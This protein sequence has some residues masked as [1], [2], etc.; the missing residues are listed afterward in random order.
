[1]CKMFILLLVQCVKRKP[2][3]TVVSGPPVNMQIQPEIVF[4]R[5]TLRADRAEANPLSQLLMPLTLRRPLVWWWSVALICKT[6]K[7]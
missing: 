5:I 4:D 6:C 2:P 3:H 7:L 1:M